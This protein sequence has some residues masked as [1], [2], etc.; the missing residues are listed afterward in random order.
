MLARHIECVFHLR[1]LQNLLYVVELFRLREVRHVPRVQEK[2]RIAWQ[3]VD[4]LNRCLQRSDYV[5]IHRFV[6]AHVA[7][8]DLHKAQFTLGRGRVQLAQ[9]AQ[10]E[11][12]HHAAIHHA[13]CPRSS[14]RHALQKAAPIDAVSVVVKLDLIFFLHVRNPFQFQNER[15]AR[16]RAA[17]GQLGQRVTN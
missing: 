9:P 7:V 12:L 13:E 14:P 17:R 16:M 3:R 5:R 11:R 1:V 2:F 10:A 8:A 4:L 15:R 6:E